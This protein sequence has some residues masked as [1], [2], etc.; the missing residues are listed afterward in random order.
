MLSRIEN[1]SIGVVPHFF[2]SRG[3]LSLTIGK[4]RWEWKSLRYT[5]DEL[6]QLIS[7][8]NGSPISFRAGGKDYWLF[9][10]RLYKDSDGLSANE[11]AALLITRTKQQR[12][13]IERA[14]VLSASPNAFVG[15]SS[16]KAIPDD[17][18]LIVWQR[19]RGKCVKCGTSV[20]L[21]FDHII[22][23]SLGGSSTPEN[24]QIL[25]GR[26][27]RTKSNSIV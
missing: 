17:V 20:E 1:F 10:G 5:I 13:R 16:R 23:V 8:S 21:Q 27:N 19:D 15:T 4:R 14:K 18:K 3:H 12:S 24:V 9:E 26:C 25:C 11:V 7:D 22:P 6:N 2:S